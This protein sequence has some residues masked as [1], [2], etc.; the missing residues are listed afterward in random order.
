VALFSA[1]LEKEELTFPTPAMTLTRDHDTLRSA[2]L[3]VRKAEYIHSL[4]EAFTSGDVTPEFLATAND[5]E[6][7]DRLTAIRGIGG[8]IQFITFSSLL[9]PVSMVGRNVPHVRS[10]A[11][12]RILHR[13]LGNPARHGRIY[14]EKCQ[15]SQNW[16]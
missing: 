4:A 3:S 14:R 9:T 12:G 13:G 2:G 1:E 15:V 5:Q 11:N 16:R 6:I 7:V 8:A 10:A